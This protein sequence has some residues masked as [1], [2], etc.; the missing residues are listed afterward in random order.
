MAAVGKGNIRH[1]AVA[2]PYVD[3]ATPAQEAIYGVLFPNM[4][5][6]NRLVKAFKDGA[7]PTRPA[8]PRPRPR[9]RPRPLRMKD[10]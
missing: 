8:Q 3:V 10:S 7:P 2:P 4:S 6:L 1:Y 9:P 5:R